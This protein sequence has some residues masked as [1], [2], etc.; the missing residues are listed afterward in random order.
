M[1]VFWGLIWN[2]W[3]IGRN[4]KILSLSSLTLIYSQGFKFPF[5][6]LMNIEKVSIFGLFAGFSLTVQLKKEVLSG[7]RLLTPVYC[8][9]ILPV[10]NIPLI[11]GSSPHESTHECGTHACAD[12]CVECTPDHDHDHHVT[13]EHASCRWWVTVFAK[14]SSRCL[15]HMTPEVSIPLIL[16]LH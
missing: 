11:D 5:L 10:Y 13:S 7:C 8:N 6:D 4:S 9:K 3:K 2:K 14:I 15:R 16:F 1:T 12:E